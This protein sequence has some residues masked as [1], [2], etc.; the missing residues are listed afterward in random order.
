MDR[1]TLKCWRMTAANLAE[2]AAGPQ[3]RNKRQ[4]T[5]SSVENL[6][7][8]AQLSENA[9]EHVA[10]SDE[11]VVNTLWKVGTAKSSQTLSVYVTDLQVAS[12]E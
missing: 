12:L 10:T 9:A 1:E 6:Q 11:P 5:R 4:N 3:I 8:A 7:A 2:L